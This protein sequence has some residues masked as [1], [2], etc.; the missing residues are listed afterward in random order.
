MVCCFISGVLVLVNLLFDLL[1]L[2]WV[3]LVAFLLL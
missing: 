1:T 3:G 2:F